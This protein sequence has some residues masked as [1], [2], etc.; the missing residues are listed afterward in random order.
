MQSPLRTV[1]NDIRSATTDLSEADKGHRF[2]VLMKR[3]FQTDPTYKER[4]SE[5]WLWNE[6]TY[7][8]GH[9]IGIDIVAKEADSDRYVAIQCKFYEPD[10]LMSAHDLDTFFMALNSSIKTEHSDKDSFAGGII[11]ATTDHW[12]KVLLDAMLTQ[13]IPCQRIGLSDL[14]EAAIDWTTI[15]KGQGE[16]TKYQ[17]RPH[18]REAIDAVM[19]GFQ[20]ADRGKLIMA[21]GTGKTFTALRLTEEYTAG[22]GCVLFLAPS[23]ALV[24]QSL[25]EWMSQTTCR[26]H[27]IAVCSDGSASS[28]D[29][30]NDLSARDLPARATTDPTTIAH[31]YSKFK[32]THLTVIFS[33][34]QSIEKL[35]EA[36][37]VGALPEF[38]LCICDE[39]H[40]TTGVSLM[41]TKTGKY[42]ESH[43]VKVHQQDFI[44]CRKRVYMTAT[45]KIYAESA[46]TKAK[47]NNAELASMD[48][49]TLFGEEFFR[50]PFSRA[51]R[52]GLLTDYKVL[53]LCV[54]EEYVKDIMGEHIKH[55]ETGAIELDDAVRLVGCY[56]G[57]RKKVML[58][59]KPEISNEDGAYDPSL[60]DLLAHDEDFLISDPAPMKRAVAFANK[61]AISKHYTEMWGKVVDAIRKDEAEDNTAFLDSEMRHVDGNMDMGERAA[62]LSW[63]KGYSGTNASDG[64]SEC[65]ILSNAR[66]L[67]EGVDVPSLDAVMFLAPRKSQVDVVQSVGRV[68]RRAQD[69]KFG[70]IILPIGVSPKDKPEDVLDKDEKYKVVWDVLQALRSH[71]DR[72]NAE[73]NSIDLNKGRGKR[74]VVGGVTGKKKGKRTGKDKGDE[75]ENQPD[76]TFIQPTLEFDFEQELSSWTDGILVRTVQ[77]C[78]DRR[79]WE[80]WAKNIAK[81]AERQISAINALLDKGIGLEEFQLFLSGLRENTNPAIT[82]ADAIEMLAQQ[83]ISRPV[84]N[85]LFEKYQFA[86]NNPVSKTMNDMLDIVHDNTDAADLRE[87]ER[88]YHSV[89][90]RAQSIDNAAG[91]QQV[92][93]EL[94][95]KF[96][97]QAFPKLASKLGI[98]YTPIPVVDFIVH[99]VHKVLQKEFGKKDGLGAQGVKILDPFTGTGTFIVRAIQSGLIKRSQLPYKY[100]NELFACEIV[101]LAYYIACVNVEVAYHGVMK[102]DEYEPFNGIC[103]TDTF[104]MDDN[105]A[106]DKDLFAAFEDNG[107]RVKNLCKQDIRVIIGN[108]PYSGGQDDANENNQNDS[109]PSLDQRIADTYASNTKT[110]YNKGL[111]NSYIR[112]FRWASDRITDDGI[113]AFVTNGL[114]IDNN[115]MS[116]FRQSIMGEFDSIYCF[117]LRGAIRGKAK[118]DAKKEGQNVFD[119]M[120]GV[121]IIIL[122]KKK[123][124]P[125]GQQATLHYHDIG[126]YLSRAQKLEII[127]K[128]GDYT[129][130]PWQSLT[131]DEHGDW[132]NHRMEEYERFL[133]IGDKKTKGKRTTAALFYNF[134]FGITTNRDAWAYNYS[135]STVLHNMHRSIDFY[136][137]QL[138]KYHSITGEKPE[139]EDFIDTDS[140]KISWSRAYRNA[141]KRGRKQFYGEHYACKAFYRPYVKQMLY[142]DKSVLNDVGPMQSFFASREKGNQVICIPGLGSRKGFSCFIANHVVDL[143]ALEAGTQCFPL[144]WYEERNADAPMLD[145]GMEADAG[146]YIRHDGI[147]DFGLKQFRSAYGDPKIGKEDIFY[148]VYGLLHSTE[149]RTRF[150]N[151]LKKEMPRIPFAKDFWAFSKAGRKLAELHLN[152][153]T[154]EPWPVKEVSNGN[155]RVTKMKFLKIKKEEFRH[156]I[157][158]N[159]TCTLSEIPEAAYEY[160][161]SGKSAIEWLIDRY[162]IKTDKDSG[163]VNDAND[164]C[165]EQGNPRYIIDLV[166]RVIRVSIETMAIVKSLPAMDEL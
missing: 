148:Y 106:A 150:E 44:A 70:Y 122:V 19:E 88:F 66:C 9:D 49:S 144:Y 94:Y 2:E 39:A 108:P 110:V 56:N 61:I 135:K 130:I 142:F 114:Y 80:D 163:I 143:N 74:I 33:T 78:G 41:D 124:H 137:N 83:F 116:C 161:I 129:G 159:D 107:E 153:E 158:Y 84:F 65:R 71:D 151:N 11:V 15:L 91:R 138:D 43:F 90:D 27:P 35:H 68:M 147:T 87:L 149:Y 48:D 38:D 96:F 13:H 162:S 160:I 115:A 77:K 166:K 58:P 128:F 50:L 30:L 154:I 86:E 152:Y 97:K 105:S 45:P 20:A 85:A 64:V 54:D 21:C 119:I 164:W 140:K 75:K 101:L 79:Y 5:V 34:Y 111:Y 55:D 139:V 146:D 29:D 69:K 123:N 95:D 63:L 113:L 72:F 7:S 4:F 32:D 42:N 109:Y 25:R 62:L 102:Q 26:I 40:R 76:G 1:L 81:I 99:S 16:I 17:P 51:V 14:E 47:D 73:I 53:V 131:P 10:H 6:W 57:L 22:K 120:T 121:A 100:R 24:A 46:R 98:V 117:N 8:K 103:L 104:R 18:Q 60:P 133:P 156:T 23:I 12:N 82:E 141:L 3:Y 59:T 145:L 157:L 52:E 132:I 89:K 112:A 118:N 136:N 155:Y 126:D 31:L 92:V 127:H 36:Q 134:S 93:V 165:D 125:A 37:K 28:I 67:S